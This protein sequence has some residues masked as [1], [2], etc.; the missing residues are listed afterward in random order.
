MPITDFFKNRE[1]NIVIS[2]SQAI[3]LAVGGG[4]VVLAVIIAIM[5]FVLPRKSFEIKISGPETA[6]A[7]ELITYTVSCKN[8]GNVALVN[9]ELVFNYSSDSLP[10]KREIIEKVTSAGFE[11]FLY[12]GEEEIFQ[13]KTRLLGAKEE[14]KEARCW[15]NYR[16]SET[17]SIQMSPISV[18]STKI[19]EV[20]IDLEIDVPQKIPI[21]QKGESEFKF[22]VS[23]ASFIDYPLSN[24]KLKVSLPSDFELEETRPE[25]KAEN[26]WEI[27]TLDKNET[28]E[29]EIWGKFPKDQELGKEM[30]FSAQLSINPYG[31]EI[32]LERIERNP[33]TYK[34]IFV[35]SQKINGQENYF[36]YPGERLHYQ[37]YFENIHDEPL[38]NLVL[39]SR[40][41]GNLFDLTTIEA[42]DGDFKAGDNSIVWSEDKIS[43]LRYLIP[44]GEGEVEF[45]VKL[46]SD[47]EPKSLS[48]TNAV[49][50]NKITLGGFEKEF[51]NKV[52]SMVKIS[53]EGYFRDKYGF[54]ENSGTPISVNKAA[55]YTIVWKLD[56][57]YNLVKGVEV[58]A[59]LPTGVAIQSTRSPSQG[60]INIEG[61]KA[62]EGAYLLIPDDFRFQRNLSYGTKSDEVKYLQIILKREVP[63][64]YPE[65]VP[66]TGYFGYIT[67]NSAV[68]FQE[69]YQKA[70][71]SPQ[72]LLQ[73]TGY[74]DEAT[75]L[76]LNELLIEGASGTAKKIV[77]KID[78][79]EPGVGVFSDP[80]MVVFQITF[81]PTLDQKGKVVNLINEVVLQGEDQWTGEVIFDSDEP[82]DSS[83]PDDS[84]IK[85]GE[86][87]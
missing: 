19:S 46:K 51:R 54:F 35:I 57:Y 7:G 31:E 53:Q 48:E 40:L 17:S 11:D 4:I 59:Q 39:I 14:I 62:G 70:I 18:F 73:G 45:W 63:S 15:L 64:V 25:P 71:L 36:P 66:A 1:G 38:R 74:V 85:S 75:R 79:I 83:L 56:N 58:K 20:P 87:R 30:S 61:E 47:Y 8:K 12:P 76:K 84:T 26:E 44:G 67:L 27:S 22:D 65:N 21:L 55:T 69:K 81:T 10:A 16:T 6:Q 43:E 29:V 24:L 23:Y 82:I 33:I 49:V 34:P 3:K 60:E 50:K 80:L 5:F 2:E 41:D 78:R 13:F 68:A 28:G 32:V 42:P 9:P 77:W 72:G 37:I 86:I 52:N